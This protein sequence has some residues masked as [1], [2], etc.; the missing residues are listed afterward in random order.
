MNRGGGEEDEELAT[1]KAEKPPK[2]WNVEQRSTIKIDIINPPLDKSTN[3]LIRPN[4]VV[5]KSI[6]NGDNYSPVISLHSP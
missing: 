2:V 5:G 6:S 3:P 4:R 1:D